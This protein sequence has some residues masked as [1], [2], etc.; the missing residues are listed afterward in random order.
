MMPSSAGVGRLTS[1]TEIDRINLPHL[2]LQRIQKSAVA[3]R[4]V[5]IL[6]QATDGD[7]YIFGGSLRRV[8]FGENSFGDLDIM[9]PNGDAR[10]FEALSAFGLSFTLNRHG[11][12][13]Y[14][15]GGQQVDLFQPSEFFNGFPDVETALRFFDLEINA[16]AL[17]LGSRHIIDP[18]RVLDQPYPTN[19][20]INWQRW[21]EMAGIELAVLAIRFVRI[22]SESPALTISLVD[23]TRIRERITPKL[24]ECDWDGV[25]DRF[26]AGKSAF[27]QR[28]DATIAMH[29]SPERRRAASLSRSRGVFDVSRSTN[30]NLLRIRE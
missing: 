21:R 25:E 6:S 28:F 16:L 1:A 10:A 29:T 13:R 5:D 3:S 9:V 20:G 30:M 26:P 22:M 7:V 15:W 23:A 11:H 4:I 17:H 19:A 18:F 2:V 12:H 24:R 27:L 14:L 8:L